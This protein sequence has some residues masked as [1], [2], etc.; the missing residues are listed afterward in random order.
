M[1]DGCKN[2]TGEYDV[3]CEVNV[4]KSDHHAC[5][6][7]PSGKK[8]HAKA[9]PNEQAALTDVL[10]R[11]KGCALSRRRSPACTTR[12]AAP[13]TTGNE[14]QASDTTPPSS[15][16]HDD[17]STSSSPC[18]ATARPTNTPPPPSPPCGCQIRPSP[19]AGKVGPDTP[20]RTGA[21][22]STTA[23]RRRGGLMLQTAGQVRG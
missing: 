21:S 10:A 16:W 8:L 19:S 2:R 4:G 15:A 20:L 13:T 7:D 17:E 3:Y 22:P 5:A 14:P 11:L 9:E 1:S 18:S 6:L 23:R 12:P